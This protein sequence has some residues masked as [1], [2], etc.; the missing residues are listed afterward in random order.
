MKCKYEVTCSRSM[1]Q[2]CIHGYNDSAQSLVTKSWSRVHNRKSNCS[3]RVSTRTRVTVYPAR[4][5]FAGIHLCLFLSL[6]ALICFCTPHTEELKP[7]PELLNSYIKRSWYLQT[8]VMDLAF[9]QLLCSSQKLLP[10]LWATVFVG[11]LW[12]VRFLAWTRIDFPSLLPYT[13]VLK[14]SFFI[15][16][17]LSIFSID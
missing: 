13:M 15:C 16:S 17:I 8:L 6:F 5:L 7:I 11:V 1:K 2:I 12:A 14:M 4:H 3:R 9:S 10:S